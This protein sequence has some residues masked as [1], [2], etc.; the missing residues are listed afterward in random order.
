M[1]TSTAT[2]P[3]TRATEGFT[4]IEVLVVVAIIGLAWTV[5]A[6]GSTSL[7]PQANLK[8]SAQALVSSLELVRSAA[9]L[10]HEPL[11]FVYDLD[12]NTYEAYFPYERDE[13]GDPKGPGKTPVMGTRPLESDIEFKSVRLPGTV[14]R[15]KGVVEMEISALGRITPHEV[16]IVNPRYPDTELLTV[17]VSGLNP[18]A[19]VLEGDV[20]MA[21][22]Q[23][24]D[25]R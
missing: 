8:S 12:H 9:Q 21:P 23:D 18:K 6:T 2:S 25:F 11:V 4:L 13:N 22:L 19:E 16:V 7:L 3:R 1:R 24:V 14:P 15:D 10:R 17:R 5:M 20:V